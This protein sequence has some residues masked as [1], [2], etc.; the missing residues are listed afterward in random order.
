ML[1]TARLRD[2]DFHLFCNTC[3]LHVHLARIVHACTC[4]LQ[5]HSHTCTC[6]CTCRSQSALETVAEQSEPAGEVDEVAKD[7]KPEPL[8]EKQLNEVPIAVEV[9]GMDVVSG[10]W[11]V[12]EDKWKYMTYCT[13]YTGCTVHVHVHVGEGTFSFV[14]SHIS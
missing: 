2:Q 6:T 7:E 14:V 13:L 4:T 5:L 9:F 8:T 12:V 3:R 1:T 10:K 11:A